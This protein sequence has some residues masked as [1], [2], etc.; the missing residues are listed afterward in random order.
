MDDIF[1]MFFNGRDPFNGNFFN[2]NEFGGPTVKIFH[3]GRPVNIN[4]QIRKPTPIIKTIE[5][6]LEEAFNGKNYALEIERWVIN[7]NIKK[8]ERENIYV[9][10][11]KGI[12]NNE[13]IFIRNKGNI[14]N[15]N[16]KGDIKIFIKIKNNSIFKRNGLDLYVKKNII[17]RSVDRVFF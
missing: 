9:N 1:K 10:I 4:R 16:N 17:K 6:S 8:T 2:N 5:I 7:E 14:I 11:P 12:D 3:N 15:E 13:I